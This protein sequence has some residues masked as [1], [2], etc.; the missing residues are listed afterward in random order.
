MGEDLAKQISNRFE[1]HYTPVHASWLNQTEI[2]IGIYLRQCLGDGHVGDIAN[3][4]KK[5]AAWNKRANKRGQIIRCRFTKTE[6]CR[7]MGHAH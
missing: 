5:T 7:S 6:A 1:M 3:L 4:K 2:A